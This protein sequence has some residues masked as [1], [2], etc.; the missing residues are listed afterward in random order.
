MTVGVGRRIW[1]LAAIG[2]LAWT[3]Q[4]QEGFPLD[5]TWRGEWGTEG[6]DANNVVII[7]KWDG[8]TV[9]GRINPGPNSIDFANAWLEP[10]D[11]GV[12][13]E[14]ETESGEPIRIEGTLTDIG[15]YNRRISGTWTQ[16]G[17]A[18]DFSIR[19]E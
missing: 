11:W 10:D 19:R 5:G 3:A 14:A 1:L 9:T 7:M 18:F 4:G 8:E 16:G 13:I 12:H 2:S 17:M 6:G 15:S